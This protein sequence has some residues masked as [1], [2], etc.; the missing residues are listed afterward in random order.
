MPSLTCRRCA[1]TKEGLEKPPFRGALGQAIQ[2][3]VCRDCWAEWHAMQT[4][5]INEYRLSLG[6]PRSQDLL[7][8]QMKTF[9]N[10][11]G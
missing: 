1:Q 5:I 11:P 10:L 4:K 9:L 2:S 6:D 7:D 8:Q 3:S